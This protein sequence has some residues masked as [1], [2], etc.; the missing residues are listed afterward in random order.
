MAVLNAGS[1]GLVIGQ[2]NDDTYFDFDAQSVS[3]AQ[4]DT[5]AELDQF[6]VVVIGDP[7]TRTALQTVA[8]ALRQWVEAGGG[9]VGTGWLIYTAGAVLGSPI[10]DINAII[11][12][13]T[14]PSYNYHQN[15]VLSVTDSTHPVTQGVANFFVNGYSEFSNN[16]VDVGATVL[17]T[18][19]GQAAVVV[20]NPGQGRGVY[21]GPTY[22]GG[23]TLNS[24]PADQLFEQ[25]VA[26]AARA[27]NRVDFYAVQ[28]SDAD[29]LV[30]RTTTPGDQAGQPQN[31]LDPI[32]ELYDP[33]GTLVASNNNGAGDGR[34]AP[35][36]YTVPTGGG[37]RYVVRVAPVT[38]AGAFTLQIGGATGASEA[39]LEVVESS[40]DDVP[41]RTDFPQTVRLTFSSQV[42][43]SSIEPADL[44]V[45]GV[46]ADSLSV[47]D[48]TTVEFTI[49]SAAAGDAHYTVTLAADAVEDLRGAQNEAFERTFEVDTTG[50]VVTASSLSPSD[51]VA[52]GQLTVTLEFSE[53]LDESIDWGQ[54]IVLV[55]EFSSATIFPHTFAYS[56]EDHQLVVEF[57]GVNDGR[58]TLVLTSGGS[59]VRDTLGNALNG[60]PSFPLPSGDGDIGP[61]DFVIEFIVDAGSELF[62]TP[63]EPKPPAGSLI[64]DPEVD[65]AF[66][67]PGDADSYSLS[68]DAGQRITA[69]LTPDD[70]TILAE[71]ELFSPNG[72]SIGVLSA[73]TAGAIVA[74]QSQ[75]ANAAGD[76]RVVARNIEGSGRFRLRVILNASVEGEL[77][78][79]AENDT[80][81]SAE[82]LDASS[83]A[84]VGTADR[85]AVSGRLSD[86]TEPDFYS[87]TL[88]AGQTA[89]VVV[90]STQPLRGV[91]L[92]NAAGALLTVARRD[93]SNVDSFIRD[94]TAP[95]AGT[96]FI[97]LTGNSGT[98]YNLV[99]TRA[100]VFDLES[101]NEP[102]LARDISRSAVVLG[103]LDEYR[104]ASLSEIRVAVLNAGNASG[105]VNQL[106]DDTFFNFNASLVSGSQINTLA[107]LE[108]FDVVVIGDPSS[109]SALQ[110][111]APALRQWV[112]AGGGVVGTGWLIYAS[113]QSNGAPIADINAIIPV[114]TS[115]FYN[116]FSNPPISI[117][118]SSHPVTMGVV[119]GFFP[120]TSVEFSTNG[121]DAG[122]SVLATANGQPTVVVGTPGNAGRSVY[123]G[124]IYM[125]SGS[126]LQ[127][128]NADRLFEQ[129][130][131]WAATSDRADYLRIEVAS[132]DEII[133]R[134]HTPG[135]GSGE[136]LNDLDPAI[137]LYDDT[138]ALVATSDNE[139]VDGR[140]A[141]LTHTAVSGGTYRILVRGSE[142]GNR[143]GGDYILEV[144]GATGA[145]PSFQVAAHQPV[146]SAFLRAFPQRY[147][148]DLS[149]S[150]LLSSLQ[151]GDLM[152]NGVQATDVT[153][154]DHDTFEF[155]IGAAEGD[156]GIYVVTI[157]S[158]A[159][160]SV[161]GQPIS[162]FSA[163]FVRD[164]LPPT[165]TGTSIAGGGVVSPGSHTIT[166]T[167][168]EPLDSSLLDVNDVELEELLSG[169]QIPASS[170][171]YDGLSNTVSVGFE[172]LIEGEYRLTL[173]AHSSAFRDRAGNLLDGAPSTVP[174]GDGVGGDDFSLM[175]IVD[176]GT[177]EYPSP[178]E[179]KQPAGSLVYDPVAEGIFHAADDA[180]SFT[181]E[182]EAGQKVSV[183]LTPSAGD[184]HAGLRLFAP[185]GAL[186]GEV[187]A[188]EP[189]ASA[190]LQTVHAVDGGTYRIEA[191]NTA[192]AGGYELRLVLNASLDR[193]DNH[194]IASAQSID[195]SAVNLLERRRSTGDIGRRGLG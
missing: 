49:S 192:G 110:S 122:A 148:I 17:G 173:L 175:F 156:D 95:S 182:I 20:G 121:A 88:D 140:N 168:S 29:A 85:L 111:I 41:R 127:T 79:G 191:F 129:A 22:M 45:N 42:L 135:D 143:A 18:A 89:T 73:S 154:I 184:I 116:S 103:H 163:S 195:A 144:Q 139:A 75:S 13:D 10:A 69:I 97:R 46:E 159:I 62:P 55:E 113:G 3:A 185:G 105:A 120:N 8:P 15:P 67:V 194:S 157:A 63:L 12:V 158:G 43:I 165:V 34:N 183:M 155:H 2:L 125:Q 119:S 82:S 76:Y 186:I 37:G 74:L 35:I 39:P 162:E 16:G 112:E 56:A 94:F 99:V 153:M 150:V 61:D 141:L 90:A 59:G 188:T 176:A 190:L 83:I 114:D 166:V 172:G 77:L 142:V 178:L 179:L 152:V 136:P 68:V 58:Y 40:L 72:D 177:T 84:L 28:A 19:N 145:S 78:S 167:L 187:L 134:T 32:L 26:W 92:W 106:N 131:A 130:V 36:N 9:V 52:P 81:A 133:I 51:I 30:I 25:A 50:P 93:A 161:S 128:G 115:P 48:G 193:S 160:A 124:P 21:L 137:E 80:L 24:G 38:G 126:T 6:D 33:T 4:I 47:I 171:V 71:L 174:S 102:A 65:G 170:L 146:D 31:D 91:E 96:Y 109:R 5:L 118:D 98:D 86:G 14:S 100:A 27:A 164:T 151:P 23:Y 53:D 149:D 189:G 64:F 181:V 44:T 169:Q 70:P 101:N 147:R 87:F 1:A 57:S 66:H 132:G 123:L 108:Q 54:S 180:D 138:G 117:V 107:E 7:S 11:P 104:G 60:A